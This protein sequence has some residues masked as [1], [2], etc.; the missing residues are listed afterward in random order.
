LTHTSTAHTDDAP[1][2]VF[3]DY[4]EETEEDFLAGEAAQSGIQD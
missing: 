4:V 3:D 2:E 1:S